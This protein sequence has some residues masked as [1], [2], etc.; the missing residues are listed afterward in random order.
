MHLKN[1]SLWRDPQSSLIRMSPGYDIL[2]TRLLIPL[3][4]DK[5]ELAL[6]VNGRKNKLKWSDFQVLGDHFKIPRKVLDRFRDKMLDTF[7]ECED[8]IQKSFLSD[9]KKE[10]F[11]D[12]LIERSKRL[13]Q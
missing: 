2:S 12:L 6:P 3:T 9:K 5:E 10:E 11:I 1:F 8:L 7:F 4:Q 13:S